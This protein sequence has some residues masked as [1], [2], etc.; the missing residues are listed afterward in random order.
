MSYSSELEQSLV[1]CQPHTGR[2]HQIRLHLQHLGHPIVNDP[3]YGFEHSK[4]YMD[5]DIYSPS[6]SVLSDDIIEQGQDLNCQ[7]CPRLTVHESKDRSSLIW[8]HAKEYKSADWTFTSPLPAWAN[9][10][11]ETIAD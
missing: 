7:V 1:Q 4:I 9:F 3:L 8:L 6:V 10:T 11:A 2:T 5:D